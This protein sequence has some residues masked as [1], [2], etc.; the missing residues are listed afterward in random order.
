MSHPPRV[1]LSIGAS[2]PVKLFSVTVGIVLIGVGLFVALI[3]YG[4]TYGRQVVV[5]SSLNDG[6]WHLD[7][8]GKLVPGPGPREPITATEAVVGGAGVLCALTIALLA[9][10]LVLRVTRTA[11]WLEGSNLH[12]R[13][14]LRTRHQNLATATI[15]GGSRLRPAGDRSVQRV[16]LI[17]ATDP[18]TGKSVTLPLRGAGLSLL[19]SDQLRMLANAITNQRTRSGPDDTAFTVA[20]R[21]RA[22]A[23]DPFS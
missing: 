6:P 7:E 1:R 12:V 22:F 19:P 15:A 5:T 10:Y 2:G 16:E 20:D 14:A 17:T 23:D 8:D 3:A 4:V 18:A 13:G 21:L 11:A 9:G